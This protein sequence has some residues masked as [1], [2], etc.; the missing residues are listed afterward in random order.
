LP[1]QHFVAYE[2]RPNRAVSD[3]ITDMWQVLQRQ[4]DEIELYSSLL[5]LSW[6]YVVPGGRFR[7]IYYWDSYLTM[8][9]LK[10]DGRHTLAGDMLQKALSCP[11]V[12]PLIKGDIS[13]LR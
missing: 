12:R 1:K 10:Q 2:H 13:A 9:G 3:Y 6:P 7:E 8:L 5:P 11:D 4:P